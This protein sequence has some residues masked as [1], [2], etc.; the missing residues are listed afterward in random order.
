MDA[1]DRTRSSP[2]LR[3]LETRTVDGVKFG[4]ETV[5][6]LL[7]ALGRPEAAYP[8]LLV[9]GTNGKGSVVA[10]VDSIL[11]A[12]G[13]RVARY[14]SPHLVRLNERFAIDGAEITNAELDAAIE[15][16]RDLAEDLIR[17]SVISAHP[18][19]FEILTVAAFYYFRQQRAEIAVVEVGMGGRLDA[20]NASEPLVSAIV[21]VDLDHEKYLGD[22]LDLI[23]QE[24]AGVLRSGR[25]TVVGRLGDLAL[26][27]VQ[28]EAEKVGAR[29]VRALQETAVEER[30]A[31]LDVRTP[32]RHYRGLQ[33]ML[34]AHQR[35]NLIVALRLLE[36]AEDA[37][38]ALDR[39]ALSIGVAATRW[40][41]RL[42][43]LPTSPRLLL[44]GA[45]NPAAAAAL[46]NFLATAPPF[47]LV[48][49]AMRDKDVASLAQSLFPRA[50]EIVLTSSDTARAAT[51]DEMAAR[52]GPLAERAHRR[53][54]SG[55]ALALA[56]E[57]VRP[58]E[59][60]V[61]TGSLYLV[62]EVRAAAC[63]AGQMPTA[64]ASRDACRSLDSLRGRA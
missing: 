40:P 35:D 28:R 23:A 29:L 50:R 20:T 22:T 47:V 53:A 48:F 18:T 32:R 25:T 5:R 37:G 63:A 41:G 56:R 7:D 55:E 38:L 31:V 64:E 43:W 62:G 1:L 60:I 57:L 16:V 26:G 54:A 24:K 17:Q 8:V 46:A 3:Y 14:T 21:T 30:G 15:T 27:A 49:G 52:C 58:G 45:H 36:A 51:P 33:P 10:L 34:G 9:A 39:E 4:L 59:T 19:F 6:A 44:D 11:R 61:V 2:A 12:A 13:R 42:E